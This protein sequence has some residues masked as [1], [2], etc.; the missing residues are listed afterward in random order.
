MNKN[1]QRAYTLVELVMV[2]AVVGV[3]AAIGVPM[4]I[5][6][7]GAFSF[8]SQLQHNAV[9]SSLV[10]MS[11]M[12]REIRRIR[13]GFAVQAAGAGTLVFTDVSGASI[14]YSL[15]GSSLQRNTDGL[16]DE[17]SALTFTYYDQNGQ[18]LAAPQ[19]AP[20]RT[21]IRLI[22]VRFSVQAGSNTVSFQFQVYPPN[23]AAGYAHFS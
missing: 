5:E 8:S 12:S 2:L 1:A 23:V 18:V 7:A 9:S 3:V 20:L 17:V 11:R 15:G 14:S 4:M 19:V 21:D 10:A 22:R 16:L 6:T 13:D